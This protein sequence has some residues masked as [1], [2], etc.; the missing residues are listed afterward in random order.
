[1][2]YESE[3]QI[4]DKEHAKYVSEWVLDTSKCKVV[5]TN[6]KTLLPE[7]KTFS[8]DYVKYHLHYRDEA[9]PNVLFQLVNSGEILDYLNDFDEKVD[10]AIDNQTELLKANS[11]EFQVANETG[12]IVTAAKIW[13][14]CIERAKE[15]VYPT[16]VYS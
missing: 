14:N 4:Y 16:M 8:S 2:I 13:N 9:M 12:N 7:S 1:M 11:K 10:E 5:H 6:P 15:I 3:S